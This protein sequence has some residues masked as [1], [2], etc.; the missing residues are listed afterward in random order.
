MTKQEY[1]KYYYEF[2][3]KRKLLSEMYYRNT[4]TLNDVNNYMGSAILD[5]ISLT[6]P[7]F[8]ED[9]K[10][11]EPLTDAEVRWTDDVVENAR[12]YDMEGVE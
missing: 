9:N 3:E 2:D 11:K 1:L 7:Y 8:S 4:I 5:L 6:A 12:F 10:D